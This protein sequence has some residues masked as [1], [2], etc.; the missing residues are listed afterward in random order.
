MPPRNAS[1]GFVSLKPTRRFPGGSKNKKAEKTRTS[2]RSGRECPD[3]KQIFARITHI[4]VCTTMNATSTQSHAM[5]TI[6][7]VTKAKHEDQTKKGD[8]QLQDEKVQSLR[9]SIT[10]APV[11]RKDK[12]VVGKHSIQGSKHDKEGPHHAV[13]ARINFVDLAGS[14]RVPKSGPRGTF[15][16]SRRSVNFSLQALHLVIEQLKSDKL[17]SRIAFNSSKLTSLLRDALGGNCRTRM[18]ATIS[19]MRS[20]REE[21]LTTLDFA[22]Q[23]M[24]ITCLVKVNMHK[25]IDLRDEINRLTAQYK[26]MIGAER[27]NGC[28]VLKDDLGSLLKDYEFLEKRMKKTYKGRLAEEEVLKAD[29]KRYL[30]E[31]GLSTE[32][33]ETLHGERTTYLTNIST[34]SAF[35]GCL[36]YYLKDGSSTTVGN[37]T[38]SDIVLRGLGMRNFMC[39][40]KTDGRK[41]TLCMNKPRPE[42]DVSPKNDL[43]IRVNGELCKS[44]EHILKNMDVIYFG[45]AMALRLCLPNEQCHPP[46]REQIHDDRLAAHFSTGDSPSF[47]DLRICVG[48]L[49]DKMGTEEA[50]ALVAKVAE[51]AKLVDEGNDIAWE[52]RTP[53]DRILLEVE[54]VWD[55]NGAEP[56]DVITIRVTQL[57]DGIQLRLDPPPY[58]TCLFFWTVAK[59]LERLELMRQKYDEFMH[60]QY[61]TNQADAETPCFEGIC[62]TMMDPWLEPTVAEISLAQYVA[63]QHAI[64]DEYDFNFDKETLTRNAS[65]RSRASVDNARTSRSSRSSLTIQRMS[66]VNDHSQS[67]CTLGR[68]QNS[69]RDLIARGGEPLVANGQGSQ[70]KASKELA[71]AKHNTVCTLEKQSDLIEMMEETI[72]DK[73]RAIE[74]MVDKVRKLEE[75]LAEKNTEQVVFPQKTQVIRKPASVLDDLK[76]V[77]K[78]MTRST[79]LGTRLNPPVLHPPVLFPPRRLLAAPSAANIKVYH[80]C[81]LRKK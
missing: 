45:K 60:R 16:S 71:K 53:E 59:F 61:E 79:I 37:T 20:H 62:N 47:L 68:L 19:P 7:I 12:E 52:M 72:K 22:E 40:I 17:R 32:G 56:E 18:I 25:K 11:P 78:R 48:D 33:I 3:G 38:D 46:K 44:E 9:E 6:R 73:N 26:Q 76:P 54:L 31:L 2:R 41:I 75:T 67:N 49:R 29:R 21:T 69:S 35:T 51:M 34:D 57:V 36:V 30:E 24:G 27:A 14:E 43:Q 1:S 81:L 50:D 77:L 65:A 5:C 63:V 80:P 58:P 74:V 28:F 13:T 23:M 42:R 4:C 15:L 70:N 64:H 66:N 8:V 39:I 10:M 55:V